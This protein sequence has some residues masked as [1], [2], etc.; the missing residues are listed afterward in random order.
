MPFFNALLAAQDYLESNTVDQCELIR[1]LACSS[2]R[3]RTENTTP[4]MR[5]LNRC[6]KLPFTTDRRARL[7]SL[8]HRIVV[9]YNSVV[10]ELWGFQ[11][12][13]RAIKHT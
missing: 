2:V 13:L 1:E 5:T 11:A 7:V 10:I 8:K 12:I 6:R 4:V 3:W 9:I